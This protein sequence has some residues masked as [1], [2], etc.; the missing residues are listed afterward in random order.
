MIRNLAIE[1]LGPH[2][3]GQ[4]CIDEGFLSIGMIYYIIVY[5]SHQLLR[6]AHFCEL[7][8][9]QQENLYEINQAQEKGSAYRIIWDNIKF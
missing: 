7:Y 6:Q 5:L 2:R 9:S 8:P 1:P 3:N 4:N